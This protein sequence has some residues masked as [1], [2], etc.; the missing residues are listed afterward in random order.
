MPQFSA[1]TAVFPQSARNVAEAPSATAAAV[2]FIGT[3]TAVRCGEDLTEVASATAVNLRSRSNIMNTNLKPAD[4][5]LS[6]RQNVKQLQA[7]EAEIKAAMIAG[8]MELSG[9][10]AIAEIKE[11]ATSRFDRKAAE[12]ELGDLSRFEVKSTAT[13]LNVTELEGVLE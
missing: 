7:R 8:E 13:V 1:V 6:I 9:D 3:A 4:E 12:A 5:L 10:F 2:P 11:R